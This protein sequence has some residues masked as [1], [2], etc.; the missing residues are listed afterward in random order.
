MKLKRIINI[1]K[2]FI[3]KFIN[4]DFNEE[5]LLEIIGANFIADKDTI[6]G[7]VNPDYITK[8]LNWYLS[9][10][11][12]IKDID[13]DETKIPQI[14]KN[15]ASKN[16]EINSNYG[17]CIFSKENY[18][19]YQNC[20][21]EL[22]K[23]PNSRRAIM[24]YTRPQMHIDYKKDNMN[25]FICTNT[26]Q[27]FIRNNHLIYIVNMRSN[28]AIFGYK[29]DYAWHHQVYIWLKFDLEKHFKKKLKKSHII[30]QAN[31]LHIYP[32]HFCLIE[33]ELEN[34]K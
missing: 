20:L 24:I 23:N 28:D 33:K 34:A 9:Q 1:R 29:N 21:H 6:F 26:I 12:F 11:L 8:E 30:W 19:Q 32:R 18:F 5:G 17:W 4:K 27:V 7:I 25:D 31:T 22:L 2:I 13:K 10:S 14:W 3:D 15:I 16:G